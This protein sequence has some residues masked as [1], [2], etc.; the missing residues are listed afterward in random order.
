MGGHGVSPGLYSFDA[1][2]GKLGDLYGRKAFFQAAIIAQTP[3]ARW[4]YGCRS[5]SP[6]FNPGWAN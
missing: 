5:A 3:H 6:I 1:P 4:Q 2:V